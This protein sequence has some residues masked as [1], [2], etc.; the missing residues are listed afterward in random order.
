MLL[1]IECGFPSGKF[2]T[3][4]ILNFCS[5]IHSEV[6]AFRKQWQEKY[7]SGNSE[8][9][10]IH[11]CQYIWRYI[12]STSED[13]PLFKIRRNVLKKQD[14]QSEFLD[15]AK[16]CSLKNIYIYKEREE[17]PL[18]KNI[19]I[20]VRNKRWSYLVKTNYF[21]FTSIWSAENFIFVDIL[22]VKVNG[23]VSLDSA[24]NISLDSE[25]RIGTIFIL[26]S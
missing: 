4:N 13:N 2:K 20:S 23:S 6:V 3:S 15:F 19:R 11:F 24:E 14:V 25:P 9:V 7:S 17:Q 12:I 5:D 8:G 22:A 21:V 18:S 16:V 1:F 10:N 26:R